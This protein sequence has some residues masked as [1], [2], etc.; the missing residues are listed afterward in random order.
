MRSDYNKL[1]LELVSIEENC[2]HMPKKPFMA[3]EKKNDGAKDS[4]NLLIEQSLT[5]QRD[6]MME[7]L[8]TKTT[9]YGRRRWKI[10][11]IRRIDSYHWVE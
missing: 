9:S 5:R 10:I 8:M 6:E 3:E 7:N 1:G 2:S 4:I 11:Y